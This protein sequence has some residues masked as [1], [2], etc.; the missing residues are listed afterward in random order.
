MP[1]APINSALN[2]AIPLTTFRRDRGHHQIGAD[3]GPPPIPS[4]RA[5]CAPRVRVAEFAQSWLKAHAF[6]RFTVTLKMTLWVTASIG[7]RGTVGAGLESDCTAARKGRTRAARAA[8]TVCRVG[9]NPRPF[10]DLRSLLRV[11]QTMADW[12]PRYV[13]LYSPPVA[14]TALSYSRPASRQAPSSQL[15][16]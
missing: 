10:T 9:L 7:R 15:K 6:R 16:S 3:P 12:S 13:H 2:V 14:R 4:R 8:G 5:G 1:S 11:S